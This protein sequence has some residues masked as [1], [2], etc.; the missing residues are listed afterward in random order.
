MIH[1][2]YKYN[3]WWDDQ[4]GQE[5]TEKMIFINWHIFFSSSSLKQKFWEERDP[6][7]LFRPRP[8]SAPGL[9]LPKNNNTCK[10]PWAFHP[11]QVS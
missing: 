10:G 7:D 5:A 6:R 11:Y 8:G 4:G 3:E 2:Y 1:M 9:I